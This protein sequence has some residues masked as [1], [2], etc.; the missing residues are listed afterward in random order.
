MTWKLVNWIGAVVAIS[1]VVFLATV[2]LC[3]T[4]ADDESERVEV[5]AYLKLDPARGLGGIRPGSE[6]LDRMLE[7][8]VRRASRPE[9]LEIAVYGGRR[10]TPVEDVILPI[11]RRLREL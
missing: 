5:E 6:E 11:Q 10:L 2:Q 7:K 8:I 3:Q 4:S 1:P 9:V